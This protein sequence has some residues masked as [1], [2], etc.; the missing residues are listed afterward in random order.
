MDVVVSPARTTARPGKR[1]L[2]HDR[3]LGVRFV[4]GADEV[5][6]GCLAG[7][8]VAAAVVLDL[9]RMRGPVAAPFAYL[10]D[11]KKL[12]P[13]RRE[14]LHRAVMTQAA[15]WSVVQVSPRQIDQHG[16]HV[17]NLAA[18]RRAIGHVARRGEV[19]LVDGFDPGDVGIPS[20]RIVKGDGTSAAIA[21]AA[22]LAKVTRDRMMERL[23]HATE[24]RWA[25]T[26]HVGYATPL[27]HERI[28]IHGVS[29]HHRRSFASTAYTEEMWTALDRAR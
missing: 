26:E 21:A 28:A 29:R 18:L 4:V 11:S 19:A 2:Q 12:T 22:V 8:L 6:R 15:A 27:H 1:L 9:E 3:K 13:D 10:D 14:R 16:V 5:G 23:D 24:R 17:A 7:P 25:F 20:Q